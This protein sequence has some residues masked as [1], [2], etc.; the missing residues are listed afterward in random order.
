M[1]SVPKSP[2]Q[3]SPWRP[4]LIPLEANTHAADAV[5]LPALNLV[6]LCN[7]H[8]DN[9]VDKFLLSLPESGAD[10]DANFLREGG[11]ADKINTISPPAR[12]LFTV[13]PPGGADNNREGTVLADVLRGSILPS[14]IPTVQTH[15]FNKNLELNDEGYDSEG[16]LPY[17]ANKQEISANNYDEEPP[18]NDDAQP[19]LSEAQPAAA[20]VE[21]TVKAV[22]SL[23]VAKLKDESKRKGCSI[24]GKKA[25]LQN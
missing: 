21:L 20:W 8:I 4:P 11:T 19:P 17:F 2:S 16:G 7:A 24:A 22:S 23:N 1:S 6:S 3:C 12:L 9:F 5:P 10:N 13:K 18:L 25:E 14:A 15:F